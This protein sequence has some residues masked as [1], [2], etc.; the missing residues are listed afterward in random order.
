[1]I[2]L[3]DIEGRKERQRQGMGKRFVHYALMRLLH[4]ET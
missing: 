1:L 3:S 4:D 2:Y